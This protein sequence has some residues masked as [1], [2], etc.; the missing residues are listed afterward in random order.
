MFL[1]NWFNV[2]NVHAALKINNNTTSRVKHSRCKFSRDKKRGGSILT[3][4][5]IY[6]HAYRQF[7]N[8]V[9]LFR[10]IC[11]DDRPTMKH[12][13]SVNFFFP[14]P[15]AFE[16]I[17]VSK[18]CDLSWTRK[19]IKTVYLLLHGRRCEYFFLS[20]HFTN[21]TIII[22]IIMAVTIS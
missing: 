18:S 22:I 16:K 9:I 19:P 10:L 11:I 12:D 5:Y 8:F 13:L 1:K 15:V 2:T 6:I 7:Q 17:R 20:F 3:K 4:V 21:I 14:P